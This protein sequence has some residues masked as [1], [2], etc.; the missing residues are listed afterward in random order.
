V[1][2]Y[3]EKIDEIAAGFSE[4]EQKCGIPFSDHWNLG[5]QWI[6]PVWKWLAGEPAQTIC[7]DYGMYEGNLLRTVLRI[8]NIADEWI[9]VATYCE[10]TEM[11]SRMTEVKE[12]ILRDIAITDSLYLRI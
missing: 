5:T 10:H 1:I 9:A 8:A 4:M 12:R 2:G 11:V 3:L 7:A 6:E